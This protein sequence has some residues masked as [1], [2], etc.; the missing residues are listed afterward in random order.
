MAEIVERKEGKYIQIR[1]RNEFGRLEAREFH[2]GDLREV[3][4]I[5]AQVQIAENTGF[6]ATI[7]K[8]GEYP[9]DS[10]VDAIRANIE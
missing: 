10:A 5:F 4:Q 9:D 3:A 8:V 6:L 7:H 2:V 1:T